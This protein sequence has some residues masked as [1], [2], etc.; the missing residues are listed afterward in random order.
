[1]LYGLGLVGR[2]TVAAAAGGQAP[3]GLSSVLE[4]L[5]VGLTENWLVGDRASVL[6]FLSRQIVRE[7]IAG[8]A[9]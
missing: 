4:P 7:V 8:A 1:V 3:T 6:D 9:P 5:W 2:E